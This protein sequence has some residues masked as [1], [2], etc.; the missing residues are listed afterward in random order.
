MRGGVNEKSLLGEWNIIEE[1]GDEVRGGEDG[2]SNITWE[3]S[4]KREHNSFNLR[5]I[6]G[7]PVNE[8]SN[9]S[10]SSLSESLAFVS[11]GSRVQP[12]SPSNCSRWVWNFL[13]KQKM[14]VINHQ[15]Y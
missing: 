12:P 7:T 15:L 14:K 8:A 9:F 11:N 4:P 3:S 1:S 13:I 5:S 2:E 6:W 10:F